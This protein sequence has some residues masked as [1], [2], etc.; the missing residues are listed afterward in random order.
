MSDNSSKESDFQEKKT[1]LKK[2][3]KGPDCNNH[4]ALENAK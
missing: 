1:A 2:E 4:T 3:G